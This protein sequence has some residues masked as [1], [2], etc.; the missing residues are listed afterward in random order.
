M[1]TKACSAQ[2]H[3]PSHQTHIV[4]FLLEYL[5]ILLAG[6]FRQQP[7]TSA[8]SACRVGR[9]HGTIK[10]ATLDLRF[11][12]PWN[13]DINSVAIRAA[14]CRRYAQRV[15]EPDTAKIGRDSI[16]VGGLQNQTTAVYLELDDRMSMCK[17][18][19]LTSG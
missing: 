16:T 11:H 10:K 3:S 13:P 8:G 4:S 2:D 7:F 9:A 15:K 14:R 18:P 17:H 1:D 12:C 6:T 5:K 19:R